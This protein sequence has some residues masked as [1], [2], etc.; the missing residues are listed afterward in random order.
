MKDQELTSEMQNFSASRTSTTSAAS[1]GQD[2]KG[3]AKQ[4][5]WS[6]SDLLGLM[7]LSGTQMTPLDEW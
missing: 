1:S 4:S 5:Y 6:P 3:G 2:A 7:D